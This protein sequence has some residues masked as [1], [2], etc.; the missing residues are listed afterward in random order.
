MGELGIIFVSLCPETSFSA[1]G[2]KLVLCSLSVTKHFFRVTTDYLKRVLF[3]YI[4]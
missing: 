1:D 4:C 3:K 2:S